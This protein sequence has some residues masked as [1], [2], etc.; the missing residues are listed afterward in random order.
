MNLNKQAKILLHG[1][2]IWYFGEGL[3]GPLYALF[4]QRIGGNILDVSWASAIYLIFAGT[5]FILFGKI[6]DVYDNKEK[7]MVAGYALNALFTFGYIFVSTP[8][9][10]FIVEAGLGIAVAMATP[11]WN[12]LYSQHEEKGEGGFQWGL[13]GGMAKI[14]T[15][16]AIIIGGYVIYFSSFTVLFALMGTIQIIATVYQAQILRKN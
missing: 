3:L 14:I 8:W 5:L 15:G 13:A 16:A 7:M 4:T 9:Q 12:A 6:I 11:A 10:L 2:N 1:G